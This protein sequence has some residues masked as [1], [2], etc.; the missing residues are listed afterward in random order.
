MGT[1]IHGYII[2][3]EEMR[4]LNN[5]SF[6]DAN[7]SYIKK[8]MMGVSAG[9]GDSF[10][11]V[12]LTPLFVSMSAMLCIDK[13]YYLSFVPIVLLAG[14]I[15]FI[16]YNGFMNGY[17]QGRESML[18]RIKEV[19]GS[20]I[21]IYFPYMFSGILGLSMSKLLFNDINQYENI[22]TLILIVF[23]SVFTFMRKRR[24]K[25]IWGKWE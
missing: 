1:P 25:W 2:A 5:Q 10:T 9:L 20:K 6:E 23:V 7:I 18:E 4:K 11:Q 3:L 24:E 19:K 8:G 21:K 12:V 16:S 14:Y 17:F 13:S 22:F 15:L